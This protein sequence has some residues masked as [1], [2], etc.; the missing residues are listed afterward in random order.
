MSTILPQKSKGSSITRVL[1]IIEAIA[2]A[3]RPLFPFDLALQLNI[4]KPSI[5]RL[6]QQLESEGFVQTDVHG[7]IVAGD[8]THT[9]AMGLWHNRQYKMERM[10]ILTRL[11]QSIGETCGLSI[12]DGT[13]MLY[14]D[15]VQTNWPL[16]IYLPHGSR[17]PIW[18]TASG[19][20]W[21]SSL[22]LAK[23]Q[24]IMNNLP[25][26]QMT[27]NTLTTVAALAEAVGRVGHSQLGTDNEEFVAGM[28][29]CSVP[30]LDPQQRLVA[31]LYTHAPTIRK[32]L[33]DLTRFEPELKRAALALGQLFQ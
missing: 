6:L 1:E 8:R 11:A 31:C 13:E 14:T 27:H 33:A 2:Q 18:C 9:M 28:V 26:T 15:R 32:S 22:P 25:L 20:L 29:A 3:E 4:P 24:R 21:L 10:A 16:Q 7:T 19:K 5:H 12:L 30:V 17:V 23:R